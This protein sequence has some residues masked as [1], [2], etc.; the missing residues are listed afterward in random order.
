MQCQTRSAKRA[1]ASDEKGQRDDGD[2][3]D[4]VNKRRRPDDTPCDDEC[5]ASIDRLPEELV[6][7]IVLGNYALDGVPSVHCPLGDRD[8]LEVGTVNRRMANIVAPLR[9]AALVRHHAPKRLALFCEYVYC[10]CAKRDCVRVYIGH[11]TPAREPVLDK[12]MSI[13]VSP[14]DK[15][16][17]AGWMVMGSPALVDAVAGRAP[18]LATHRNTTNYGASLGSCSTWRPWSVPELARLLWTRITL[19]IAEESNHDAQTGSPRSRLCILVHLGFRTRAA[20]SIRGSDADKALRR[21]MGV[22]ARW[23]SL[24]GDARLHI[25]PMADV[26]R[27]WCNDPETTRL[28]AQ[29]V[30]RVCGGLPF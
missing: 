26:W 30:R 23:Q 7:L 22:G 29:H 6:E 25:H 9:P 27:R 20:Y 16:D 19:Q 5:V 1:R 28:A 10:L 17:A 12:G 8:L 11:L 3:R 2:E 24:G 15:A 18:H 13:G 21:T 14:N 4:G